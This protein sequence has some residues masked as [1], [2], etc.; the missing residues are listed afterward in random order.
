ME[1]LNDV[2]AKRFGKTLVHLL[3]VIDPERKYPI[4]KTLGEAWDRINLTEQQRLYLYLLYKK[5][6]GET[7]Y[8]TPLDII[9]NC[10][11]YPTN[12][13][14]R[15]MINTLMKSN[16]RMVIANFNGSYGTY[17]LDEAK[18]WEMTDKKPLNY[19]PSPTPEKRS[20]PDPPDFPPP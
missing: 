7:F 4:D 19:H 9:T 3:K 12:W 20:G 2:I 16:T 10:H 1:T 5:W 17:T 8:G 15:P 18:V 13:N 11:P 6:R 14:G